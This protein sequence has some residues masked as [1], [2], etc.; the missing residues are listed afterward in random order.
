M[1]KLIVS[2]EN[3]MVLHSED[4][5][6]AYYQVKQPDMKIILVHD[7]GMEDV[8]ALAQSLH[9]K[10]ER[11]SPFLIVFDKEKKTQFDDLD[12]I[13]KFAERVSTNTSPNIEVNMEKLALKLIRENPIPIRS[14]NEYDGLVIRDVDYRPK[15]PHRNNKSRN[16]KLRRR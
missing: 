6:Y 7:I 12:S 4:E 9:A 16:C 14:I 8:K 3:V 5:K 11:V 15:N 13:V 10:Q 2:N 1:S